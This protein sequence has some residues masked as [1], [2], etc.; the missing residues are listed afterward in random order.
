MSPE[1]LIKQHTK[2]LLLGHRQPFCSRRGK[3]S[4]SESISPCSDACISSGS[5]RVG[6]VAVTS[7]PNNLNHHLNYSHNNDTGALHYE[8]YC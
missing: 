8:H 7:P 5:A 6:V 4:E 1:H 2:S 3:K